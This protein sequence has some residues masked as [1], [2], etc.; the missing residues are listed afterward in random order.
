MIRVAADLLETIRS[1]GEAFG[2]VLR[3]ELEAFKGDLGASGRLALKGIKLAGL[4]VFFL[5]WLIGVLIFLLIAILAQTFGTWQAALIVSA[6]LLV[7]TLVLG[8][9]AYSA[10]RRVTGPKEMARQ[11]VQDHVDWIKGELV[12]VESQ[13]GADDD[14]RDVE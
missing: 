9:W 2:E 14:A 6:V 11:H 13:D 8:F 12:A 5:F 3:A 1:L 4:A 7:I 10:F